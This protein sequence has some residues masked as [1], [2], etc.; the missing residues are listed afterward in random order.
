[1]KGFSVEPDGTALALPAQITIPYTASEFD[2]TQGIPLEDFLGV[3]FMDAL[4]GSLEFLTGFSQDRIAH[5]L[6]GTVSHFSVYLNTN[7]ARLCPPP[8]AQ[9][10]CPNTAPVSP[11]QL[12]A[13]MVH[14]FQVG[15]PGFTLG[16]EGTWL[17]LRYLLAKLNSPDAARNRVDAWRFDWDSAWTPFENSAGYLNSAL[18][19]VESIELGPQPHLVNLVAHSFGGIL[20]RTY[21]EGYATDPQNASNTITYRQDVNRA[22]TMATPHSG[23]GG[24][25]STYFANVCASKAQARLREDKHQPITCFEASTGIVGVPGTGAFLNKVNGT[26]LPALESS[27]TPQY[28]LIAG[29]RIS[30]PLIGACSLQQDDGLITTTGNN[31]CGTLPGGSGVTVGD[32]SKTSV[33]EEINSDNI[34]VPAGAGLCHSSS[35][36][37]TT[38]FTFPDFNIAIAAVYDRSHPLW[39][40]ICTFLGCTSSLAPVTT[41]PPTSITSTS[42]VLN[43]TINSN[44]TAGC[45]SFEYGTDPNLTNPFGVGSFTVLANNTTQSFST[46][47]ILSPNTTY[48]YAMLYSPSC[49]GGSQA[50][51]ILSFKTLPFVVTTL[52]ATSITSTSA[53]LNG[54]INSNGTAGCADFEYGTDPNLTS[55]FGAGNFTVLANN[56]TQSFSTS[57]ILSPNTTYYYA[58]LFSPS[59]NRL[60]AGNIVSFN[61]LP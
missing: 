49:N 21:L 42:A 12:P 20:I 51:S 26:S 44:G 18:Q 19:Y 10:D 7:I 58:M 8:T 35:L 16:D 46:S 22:M 14:G 23:I 13:V 24:N 41:L 27:L 5:L 34:T 52:A 37:T 36:S 17:R 28:D 59:C 56:T 29:R 30:C 47:V 57:V 32:C 25:F 61:T 43:G 50:G 55:P 31:L 3:Y 53:V 54:T 39:D 6:T 15:V 40:K 4:D 38:C 9:S 2:T 48:Y 1:M 45:A 33:T 60:Q 11:L